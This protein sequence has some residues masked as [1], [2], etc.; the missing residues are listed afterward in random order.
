MIQKL[1]KPILLVF[2][3]IV[4]VFAIVPISASAAELSGYIEMDQ[5]QVGDI[6]GAD[7]EHI[8][9]DGYTL[10]LEAGR[11]GDY[12]GVK[13]EDTVLGDFYFQSGY[14]TVSF[15]DYSSGFYYPYD[16]N[17]N[18]CEAFIVTAVDH[19]EKKFTVAGYSEPDNPVLLDRSVQYR[20]CNG[21]GYYTRNTPAESTYKVNTGNRKWAD[22]TWYVVTEDVT[23][24]KRIEIS[25]T[26]NLVLCD[27]ATLTAKQGISVNSDEYGY[28]NSALNIYAQSRGTGALYAGTTDGTSTT[29]NDSPQNAAIGGDG[30]ISNGDIT[31]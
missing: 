5:L 21:I 14:G 23:F 2:M 28:Y 29:M 15:I 13:S 30:Y 25:G 22:N 31:I 18:L 26:V 24:E 16:E 20:Y 12:D 6:I 19:D 11:H 8:L 10:T 17:G 3:V 1:K 9:D 27:G 7:V 4:S